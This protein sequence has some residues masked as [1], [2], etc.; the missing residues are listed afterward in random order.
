MK[1]NQPSSPVLLRKDSL[2][3]ELEVVQSARKRPPMSASTSQSAKKRR[4]EGPSTS[5]EE[6]LVYL[7]VPFG[8][9]LGAYGVY[10]TVV[11]A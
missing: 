8:A 9:F 5:L 1:G 2:E 6:A 11:S 7:L 3:G 10:M 4:K